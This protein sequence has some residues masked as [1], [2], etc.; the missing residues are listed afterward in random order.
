MIHLFHFCHEMEPLV[1]FH[2]LCNNLDS[3]GNS[4]FTIMTHYLPKEAAWIKTEEYLI[5]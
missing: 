4:V 2:V 5:K 3:Y 1:A